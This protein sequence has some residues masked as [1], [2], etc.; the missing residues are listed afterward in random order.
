MKKLTE[1][2]MTLIVVT[3]EIAFANEVADRFV[4][5]A[6]GM[7]PEESPPAEFFKNPKNE[8]LREFLRRTITREE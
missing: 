6:D 2:G 3:H 4:F 1:E 5:M 8:R 7:V